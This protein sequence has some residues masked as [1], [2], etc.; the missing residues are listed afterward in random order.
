M[1]EIGRDIKAAAKLLLAGKLVAIPTET[2]YGLAA[3]ALDEEAVLSVFEAKQRPFFDPLIIHV[4]SLL[5][6]KKYATFHDERLLGL[7]KQFWPGPL[8]LLL[9]K[10]D[11]IPA[12][13]TSGLQQVA[14]RVP[15]HHLTLELLKTINV[16]LA[17]PSANPF[18]YVSPT[19]ALHVEKQL[20]KKIDYI[21]DGGPSQVGLES[22]IIGIEDNMVCVYRLGGLSLEDIE[23]KTGPLELRLNNS[24]N[25]KAPGQLKNHY[26]PKK[27]LYLGD[28]Q[29]LLKQHSGK[30]MS[31][32]SFGSKKQSGHHHIHYS[33]STKKD[34]REAALHLFRILR[35][36]DEDGSEIVL[37]ERLP[38]EGLGRAI[39]DRL[40]RAATSDANPH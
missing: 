37:C 14:V 2:V 3:N 17:A 13:V 31:L 27:P 16:P 22:T 25:P 26:A 30:T 9:P 7:A 34:L 19:E 23:K 12:L 32:I 10:K 24:S 11:V 36:A 21:L 20:G 40:K 35:L 29:E 18:G 8:T 28:L 6:A 33:L 39:N 4:P 38:D 5:E 1:A 15:D